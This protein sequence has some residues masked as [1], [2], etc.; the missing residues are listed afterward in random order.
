MINYLS[1][2]RDFFKG[3]VVHWDKATWIL[4][5]VT[6]VNMKKETVCNLP[7]P[8]NVLFPT[9]RT[10]DHHKLVCTTLNGKITVVNNSEQQD[11]LITEFRRKI[12][13]LAELA[14]GR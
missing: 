6:G 8:R 4:M 5:N 3:N 14:R 7:E 10:Y 2:F 9:K 13:S 1:T 11:S 12:T